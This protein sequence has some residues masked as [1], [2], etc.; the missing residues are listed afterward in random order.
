MAV[1]K[2][3][4]SSG[5]G[6]TASLSWSHVVPS[7][8][9]RVLLVGVSILSD[10]IES[11]AVVF[12][13]SESFTVVRRSINNGAQTCSI[14]R[15]LNPTVTTANIVVTIESMVQVI[16]GAVDFNGAGTPDNADG[17]TPDAATSTSLTITGD[18]ADN[19][20]F[21]VVAK[22]GGAPTEGVDQTADW[23][24]GSGALEGAGSTQDGQDGG[25]MSWSSGSDDWA[26]AACRIPEAVVDDNSSSSSVSSVSSVSSQSS[27]S[28][29]DSFIFDQRRMRMRV[30]KTL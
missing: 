9:D 14:W 22:D 24:L 25:A 5:S 7:G 19:F 15:L 18:T 28:S 3:N 23:N 11:T 1:A 10:A 20:M 8:S 21:D 17:A 30:L 6:N 16:G 26:H 27:S 12:N 2:G 29:Q 4:T 13:T